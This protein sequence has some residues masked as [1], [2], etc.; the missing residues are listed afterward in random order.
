MFN[1]IVS[2]LVAGVI[3]SSGAQYLGDIE[4]HAQ[5]VSDV[6][7]AHTIQRFDEY[8]K[9]LPGIVDRSSQPTY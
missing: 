5:Q 4:T 9:I 1:L 2:L 8:E 6:Y 3:T 7:M